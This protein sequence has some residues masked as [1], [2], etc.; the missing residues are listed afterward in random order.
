MYLCR[1][2][3]L[4]SH[5]KRDL[6]TMKKWAAL[7]Q[8]QCLRLMNIGIRKHSKLG[9]WGL[10]TFCIHRLDGLLGQ[11]HGGLRWSGWLRSAFPLNFDLPMS[12]DP[13]VLRWVWGL[14]RWLSLIRWSTD[15]R[16][17]GRSPLLWENQV[18]PGAIRRGL[19]ALGQAW[20]TLHGALYSVMATW[21]EVQ[22][23]ET[24]QDPPS[25]LLNSNIPEKPFKILTIIL[26]ARA[27]QTDL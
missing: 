25:L 6:M 21:P 17:E 27:G 19:I 7:I 22:S 20:L 16:W 26:S 10:N 12:L 4:H 8:L 14:N 24:S 18:E 13:M 1:E 2:G 23:L 9:L 5:T 3:A 11:G 15:Q